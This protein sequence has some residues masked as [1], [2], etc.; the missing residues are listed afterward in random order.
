MLS[1]LFCIAHF[2]LATSDKLAKGLHE[3]L[4]N[5]QFIFSKCEDIKKTY[6]S[7]KEGILIG[8]AYGW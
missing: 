1:G 2:G 7:L 3:T 6:N 8:I 5:L 4:Q